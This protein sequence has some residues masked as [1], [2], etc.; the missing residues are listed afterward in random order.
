MLPREKA[1]NIGI[2]SLS[3]EELLA[4]IIKSGYKDN[5]VFMLSRALIDKANGFENLLSLNYEELVEIKGIKNAKALEILAI[6]EIAKR[7]SNYKVVKEECINSPS[8]LLEWLKFNIGFS[9]Q[10]EFL[11]VF[12]STSGKILKSEV[13][14]K[15]TR[16]ASIVGVDEVMR[17]AILLKSSG[18]VVCHNHPSGRVNPSSADIEITKNLKNA[19]EMLGLK[20]YDHIIVSKEGY[21]SFKQAKLIW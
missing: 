16:N 13:L 11:V 18:I 2:N 17:K 6:L 19:S 15:G 9:N 10:E 14:F 12:L 3:N 21:Y 8:N 1:L 7:L 4:L 20:F 5:D